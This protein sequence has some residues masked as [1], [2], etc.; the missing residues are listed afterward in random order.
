[1]Q[2]ATGAYVLGSRSPG[3]VPAWR[4]PAGAT[5][6]LDLRSLPEQAQTVVASASALFVFPDGVSLPPGYDLIATD[7]Q[8]TLSGA[9][10]ARL[11]AMMQAGPLARTRLH[12]VLYELLT[13]H[14]D[15]TG[16]RWC[17]PLM[18]TTQR[19]IG[20][21]L[22]HQRAI[23]RPFSVGGPEWPLIQQVLQQQYRQ[24]RLDALA[25]RVR[26][27]RGEI[28]TDFHQQRL[29]VWIEK[30]RL[31]PSQFTLFVPDDLPK[32][33]LPR[34]HRTTHSDNFNGADS[35]TLGIQLTWTE[36]L[37]AW[38]NNTNSAQT[39][40]TTTD[41]TARA[42]HDLS[43]DD[44]ASQNTLVSNGGDDASQAAALCR[45]HASAET[46]YSGWSGSV[47]TNTHYWIYKFVTGTPTELFTDSDAGDPPASFTIKL[48]VNGSDLEVWID[49]VSQLTGSDSSITGHTR[50]GI[51]AY[52]P[53]GQV[54]LDDFSVTDLAAA[55]IGAKLIF[56]NRDYV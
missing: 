3:G 53:A 24:A 55:A 8:E 18:P 9:S 37:G 32:T 2:I 56:R 49:G 6:S 14:A 42:E 25:G 38:N 1:M 4:L 39:G 51:G 31:D 46:H 10:I 5:H 41:Y 35:G 34:P 23:D 44:Q 29:S 17:P 40:L 11:R 27:G 30:F 19:R 43:S 50:G 33:E 20:L 52:E 26:D 15:P 28:V 12:E 13:E 47:G 48:T 36:G 54:R 22:G 16:A 7:P 21:W 45:Y